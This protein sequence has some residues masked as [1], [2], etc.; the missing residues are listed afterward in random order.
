VLKVLLDAPIMPVKTPEAI[1]KPAH[2]VCPLQVLSRSGGLYTRGAD[3]KVKGESYY[4]R[5]V[6]A[7]KE[8]GYQGYIGYELCHPPHKV[9]PDG[10][11]LLRGKERANGRGVHA[12]GYR[13]GR[14]L[15]RAARTLQGAMQPLASFQATLCGPKSSRPQRGV[16]CASTVF[17][18][19]KPGAATSC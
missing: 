2:D 15:T 5:F 10:G 6:R 13:R 19:L 9:G 14:G 7:M 17:G 8:I 3:G 11:H 1:R 18:K 12:W 16:F 4:A